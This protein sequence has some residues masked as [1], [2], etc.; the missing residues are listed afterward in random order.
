[1]R[2]I[3]VH[4]LV[5][6]AVQQAAA[7]PRDDLLHEATAWLLNGDALPPDIDD[8]LMQLEPGERVEVLVF[9]RRSGLLTTPVWSA[10]HMLAPAVKAERGE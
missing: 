4:L 6:T 7:T 5:L 10:E 2:L 1:M 3:L 9:L 8:R